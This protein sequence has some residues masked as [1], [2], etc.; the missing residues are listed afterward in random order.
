MTG[1][2]TEVGDVPLGSVPIGTEPWRA[3][4]EQH[5]RTSPTLE[6]VRRMNRSRLLAEADADYWYLRARYTEP[7]LRD[8]YLAASAGDDLPA[9]HPGHPDELERTRAW[10]SRGDERK[11]RRAREAA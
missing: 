1:L 4:Y 9:H 2:W 11:E 5:L 10:A 8:M 6:L 3:A 7:E